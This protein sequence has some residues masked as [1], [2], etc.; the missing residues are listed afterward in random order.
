MIHDIEKGENEQLQSQLAKEIEVL[1]GQ[2][3]GKDSEAP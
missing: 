3:D 1:L 2:S